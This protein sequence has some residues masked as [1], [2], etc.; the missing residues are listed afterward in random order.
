MKVI[1]LIRD[2][3]KQGD[4]NLVYLQLWN[5]C[6]AA[7]ISILLGSLLVS[8]LLYSISV[9]QCSLLNISQCLSAIVTAGRLIIDIAPFAGP[10][11]S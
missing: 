8:P 10:Q 11:S 5:L 2:S 4:Q 1:S 3:I 6:G 7:T 9:M